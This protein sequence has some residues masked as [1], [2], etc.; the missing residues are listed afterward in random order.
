MAGRGS[1]CR[2]CD[3]LHLS[4]KVPVMDSILVATLVAG[5]MLVRDWAT[6]GKNNSLMKQET[7]KM[8]KMN[9]NLIVMAV[10]M[11]M[12]LS[13]VACGSPDNPRSPLGWQGNGSGW[14]NKTRC[15]SQCVDFLDTNELLSGRQS[16]KAC[17][18]L[19]DR[20]EL[21][22]ANPST[23]CHSDSIQGLPK[24][25]L[26]YVGRNGDVGTESNKMCSQSISKP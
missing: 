23:A 25:W 18:Q 12:G 15:N 17:V 14:S 3:L 13:L 20:A 26:V 9:L 5:G 19:C 11:V 16:N 22:L 8:R 6:C 1:E 10:A 24:G 7:T 2:M 21:T 4:T